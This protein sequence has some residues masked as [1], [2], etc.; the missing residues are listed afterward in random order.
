MAMDDLVATCGSDRRYCGTVIAVIEQA[1]LV[2]A[3]LLESCASSQP[4]IIRS[5]AATALDTASSPGPLPVALAPALA[6]CTDHN[7][8]D[9]PLNAMVYTLKCIKSMDK[10][11]VRYPYT[12]PIQPLYNPYIT[13]I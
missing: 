9:V 10:E 11:Q 3:T 12:T 5:A 4:K 13:P 7:N 2:A 1:P 8:K 6:K